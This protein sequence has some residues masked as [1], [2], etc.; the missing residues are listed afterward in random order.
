MNLLKNIYF[1]NKGQRTGQFLV[2]VGYDETDKNYSVL[3]LPESEPIYISEKDVTNGIETKILDFVDQLPTEE[4]EEC[5][6]EF[7]YR[8]NNK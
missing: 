1:V 3:G 2:M 8:I 5:K 4:Y 7:T 6:N